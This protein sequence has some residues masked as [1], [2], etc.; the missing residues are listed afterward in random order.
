MQFG[1]TCIIFVLFFRIVL[2]IL[3]FLSIDFDQKRILKKISEYLFFHILGN[4][5]KVSERV[6]GGGQTFFEP[7]APEGVGIKKLCQRRR[8]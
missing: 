6:L 4:C 3:L 8:K 2:R 1:Q 5:E 7:K